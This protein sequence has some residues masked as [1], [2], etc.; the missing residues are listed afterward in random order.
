MPL[1]GGAPKPA[2]VL[3]LRV[4]AV[5]SAIGADLRDRVG[6]GAGHPQCLL[7]AHEGR[8]GREPSPKAQ[9]VA[10]VSPACAAAADVTLDDRHAQGW[11]VAHKVDR[12]PKAA[13]AAA[14]DGD[15]IVST[16]M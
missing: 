15:I 1:A 7:F 4:D 9:N 6:R 11:L 3:V 8:H 14:H 5:L 16:P 13:E 10:G 12:C 2:V